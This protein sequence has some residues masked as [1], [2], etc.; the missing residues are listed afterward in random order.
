MR[1]EKGFT[2]VDI[3]VGT[4][5]L[6]MFITLIATLS[7]NFNS[8]NREIQLKT[9]AV[10]YAIDE[11]EKVKSQDFS[12]YEPYS[13]TKPIPNSLEVPILDSEN[14]ETGMYLTTTVEDYTDIFGTA[15]NTKNMVKKN[16]CKNLIYV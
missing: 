6:F 10:F 1:S 9:E 7:Y 4:I 5:L 15:G 14:K 13:K 8:G 12:M 2:G 16:N 3:T 11:I